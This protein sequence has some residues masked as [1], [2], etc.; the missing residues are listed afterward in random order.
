MLK[1]NKTLNAK[2]IKTIDPM[3]VGSGYVIPSSIFRCRNEFIL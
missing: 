1:I 2:E 3:R